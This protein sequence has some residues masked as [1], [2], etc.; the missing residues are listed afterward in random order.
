MTPGEHIREELKKRGWGQ[1]DLARILNR[2]AP[3]ITELV[4]GKL[5]ISPEIAVALSAALGSTPEEWLSREAA[6]RLSL[7]EGVGGG[8]EV[9]RRARLYELAPVKEMQKRGWVKPTSS[10]EQLERELL[11]YY[12]IKNLDEQ[13]AIHG[14]M[15]KTAP[16]VAASS[17][18]MAWA[19]RV[20]QV[21]AAIPTA[22]IGTYDELK[23]VACQREI[24]KLASYSAGASKAPALLMSY[25]IRYVVVEG[26]PG[27]KMDGFATW[28]DPETPVIGM[29]LRYDRLDWFWF[30][31]GHEIVHIKYRD[32]APIDV[33]SGADELPLDVKPPME[34]RADQESAETFIP[35]D[36]LDSFVRRV[37]PL[38]SIEKINKFAN[39]IKVHP[40]IIVGQ[41]KNRGEIEPRNFNK[42][43]VPIRDR[44]VKSA[45]AD[46]WGKT[47]NLG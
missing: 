31:L 16:A 29:S 41:L 42:I 9:R 32:I 18:Q 33:N 46:G 44:V 7:A 38:Y 36:E 43:T 20:R 5:L 27:A 17:A 34:R 35:A 4:Q 11:A 1:D 22:S 3:R 6:Y 25:G 45:V 28:L 19:F 26:L 14:A 24:R 47:V 2:P 21:A 30:T 40:N 15:R 12:Q 39:R 8:A 10:T 13:P 37:G 23:L